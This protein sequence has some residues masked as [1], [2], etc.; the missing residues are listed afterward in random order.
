MAAAGE[1]EPHGAGGCA[2]AAPSSGS[3]EDNYALN[4]VALP[5]SGGPYDVTLSNDSAG[6]ALRGTVACDT[7]TQ[8]TRVPPP[9]VAGGGADARRRHSIPPAASR[10]SR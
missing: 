7:G 5:D 9:D 6:G 10:W 4:W 1:T 2:S 8:I 3:V